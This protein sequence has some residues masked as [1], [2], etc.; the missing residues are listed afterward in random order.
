MRAAVDPLFANMFDSA[1]RVVLGVLAVAGGF[2]IGN[3]LT[4]LGLRLL[5]K[6]ALKRKFNEMLEKALRVIGGLVLAVLVAFLVFRGGSGWGFGGGGA[7]DGSDPNGEGKAVE[8]SPE[9]AKDKKVEPPKIDSKT[10]EIDQIGVTV[11]T[12]REYPKT[13]KFDGER[14]GRDLTEAKARLKELLEQSHGKLRLLTIW[15]YHDSTASDHPDLRSFQ[16]YART[17]DISPLVKKPDRKLGE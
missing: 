3:L 14:E 10:I 6:F 13:F 12:A 16:E 4:L 9:K 11:L 7:G 15:I 5:A 8:P 2:L 1:G 17:L